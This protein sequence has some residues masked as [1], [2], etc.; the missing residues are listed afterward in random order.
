VTTRVS[1]RPRRLSLVATLLAFALAL[2]LLALAQQVPGRTLGVRWHEG[3]PQLDFSAR[4]LAT[5]EVRR[6]LDSGLPQ[7][8]VLRVA[9]LRS[10]E[11]STPI[12]LAAQTCRV[13]NALLYNTYRVQV[14]TVAGTVTESI[15]TLD[16]VIR[17]CLVER[18]IAVGSRG[19]Y[20]ARRGERVYF[21]VLLEFNPLSPDTVRRIR[22]WLA[23]S[24]GG[25]VQNDA[26]FGS[27]VNLFVN[28]RIGS[29]EHV[30]RFRSQP[31]R[32]P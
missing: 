28:H 5:A 7:T 31:V 14:T 3:V 15:P 26:F 24:G 29:A 9:A 18:G 25:P 2:P 17:R 13:T 20:E 23:N 30:L 4:D 10:S 16:G 22:R 19:V 11:P 21:A 12:A 6:K 1:R 32:V 8:L 27:F